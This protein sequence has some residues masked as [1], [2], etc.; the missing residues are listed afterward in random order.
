MKNI[1]I[2]LNTNN[3]WEGLKIMKDALRQAGCYDFKIKTRGDSKVAYNE[4]GDK[5]FNLHY[6]AKTDTYELIAY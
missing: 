6:I 1:K 4:F 5:V 3:P 2:A